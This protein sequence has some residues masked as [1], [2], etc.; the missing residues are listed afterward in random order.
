[1]V[2]IDWTD[3]EPYEIMGYEFDDDYIR[4]EVVLVPCNYLHTMLGYQEDSISSECIGDL[5]E[6]IKYM[7]PSQFIVYTD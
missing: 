2:C 3:V 4:L 7:G 5:D 6:Q 1:M